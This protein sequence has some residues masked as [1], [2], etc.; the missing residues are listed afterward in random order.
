M[1]CIGKI[2]FKSENRLFSFQSE[3]LSLKPGDWCVVKT[4]MGLRL[5]EVIVE[6][7]PIDFEPK[8]LCGM[9]KAIRKASSEDKK[10][11]EELLRLEEEAFKIC[12]NRIE[13]RELSMKLVGVEVAFDKSKILFYFRSE[14]RVDFRELV[15]DLAHQFRTRIELR[16]IGVRDEARMV[17]GIGCCGRPLCC[18]S[19]LQEF[20]PVSI[21]MAKKQSLAL[22]PTKISGQCGRLMCCIQYEYACYAQAG[23]PAKETP[24]EDSADVVD[25][26]GDIETQSGEQGA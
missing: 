13:E 19:F 12:E 3:G 20:S 8:C 7:R 22:N 14:T 9:M 25:E 21:K 17:G 18:V 16:Q 24:E 11:Y 26:A 15:K 4:N 6:P 23:G 10:N 5:G 2:K 1:I